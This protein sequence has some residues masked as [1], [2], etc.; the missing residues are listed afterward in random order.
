VVVP[1]GRERSDFDDEPQTDPIAFWPVSQGW[2][3]PEKLSHVAGR[4]EFCLHRIELEATYLKLFG[5]VTSAREALIRYEFFLEFNSFLGIDSKQT[6]ETFAY[7][8]K[9]YPRVSFYFWPS[10][11][12]FSSEPFLADALRIYRDIQK[13]KRDFL[14]R[15]LFDEGLLGFLVGPGG[16]Q[17]YLRF[18]KQLRI[19]HS[20][21]FMQMNRFPLWTGWPRELEEP[22]KQVKLL[23]Q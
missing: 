22:L 1:A 8:S 4:I 7:V 14:R 15:V 9:A 10:F 5:S 17:I 21:L 23:L 6:P 19:G 18:L 12:A 20:Q 11:V 13:G 2:G 3:S 16:D